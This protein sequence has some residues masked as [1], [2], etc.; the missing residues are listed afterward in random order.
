MSYFCMN[1]GYINAIKEIEQ[2]LQMRAGKSGFDDIA[3]ACGR[4]Y[5]ISTLND[6]H[7]FS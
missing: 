2:Q 7:Y 6:F 1:R 3:V 4:F 5:F